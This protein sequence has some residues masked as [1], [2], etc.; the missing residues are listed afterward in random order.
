ML[1]L[2]KEEQAWLDAYREALKKQH[3][4]A[5]Q[6]MLIYGSQRPEV[7]LMRKAISTCF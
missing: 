4:E 2:T 7:R 5:V 6:E 3:P 1:E